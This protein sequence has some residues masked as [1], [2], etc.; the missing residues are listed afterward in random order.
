MAKQLGNTRAVCRK[1]YVHP[2]ILEAYLEGVTIPPRPSDGSERRVYGSPAA[3]RR[4]ELAV[5][6][7]L[8]QRGKSEPLKLIGDTS[9][10][11]LGEEMDESESEDAA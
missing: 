4:D 6:E 9:R 3:L 11:P 1:Y 5:I 8:R 7:M 10:D 2:V